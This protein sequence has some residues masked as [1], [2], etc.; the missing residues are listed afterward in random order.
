MARITDP[1]KLERIKQATIEMI[2]THGYGGASISIIAA[3]AGVADGYLYRHYSSKNLLVRDLFNESVEVFNTLFIQS[4]ELQ[5]SITE[6]ICHYHRAL[7]ERAREY[8]E[9]AK[10]FLMLINDFTFEIDDSIK[11]N[12]LLL[13]EKL[14][15]R[16]I[17]QG[18]ISDRTAIFEIYAVMITI[19]MQML[20]LHLRGMFSQTDLDDHLAERISEI[21]LKVISR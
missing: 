4:L 3:R 10:F 1:T 21:C 14:L 7:V 20:N 11:K 12:T 13:C 18:E 19:P 5:G 2:V 15:S 16:G 6:I 8:P 17:R 9:N